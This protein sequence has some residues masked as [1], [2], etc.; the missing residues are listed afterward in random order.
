MSVHK[1]LFECVEVSLLHMWIFEDIHVDLRMSAYD[2]YI[3]F[4]FLGGFPVKGGKSAINEFVKKYCY[5]FGQI[6]LDFSIEEF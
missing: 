4:Y 2:A 5:V 1:Y 6:I 3:L